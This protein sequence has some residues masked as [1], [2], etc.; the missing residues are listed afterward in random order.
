MPSE[1][2]HTQCL[3]KSYGLN[4]SQL[5]HIRQ[6]EKVCNQFE[7]L[8]MKLN[9]NSL[10]RRPTNEINDFLYYEA[11]K[12]VG[13]LALYSFNKKEAEVSA[14]THPDN[15][16]R[17]IFKQLLA[18]ARSELRKRHIPDFLFICER[19]SVS[20]R[21]CMPAI[22]ARYEFSEYKM[23]L[24]EA[25][26]PASIS[27]DLQ[28][29]PALPEDIDI[30]A[31]ME[32]ICFDLPLEETKRHVERSLS[33]PGRRILVATVGGEKIGKINLLTTQ[34]ETYIAAFC[35]LPAHRKKGYGKTILSRTVEELVSQ[36][37]QNIS[38]EVATDNEHALVLY[39]RCGFQLTAAY[40]YYR[41][42]V[43][44]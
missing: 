38:L 43:E 11:D 41:L 32:A 13:Y 31:H 15:R 39:Q 27:A 40:D 9:W 30:L 21:H 16:Q 12:L 5:A 17:G 8:K 1:N 3:E 24:Q 7:G 34:A 35:V 10:Q 36:N 14:M 42:P 22:G 33:D 44:A 29:R 18:V 37:Y 23:G 4:D 2:V 20:G 19:A 6:L 25:V 26:K 28:L